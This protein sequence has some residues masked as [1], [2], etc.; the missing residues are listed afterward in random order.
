MAEP[1]TPVPALLA[2]RCAICGTEGEATELFPA[3][4]TSDAF[5][6]RHFSAR[7]LPDRV[8][9]RMVRCNRCGLIRADP[10]ADPATLAHLYERSSFDYGAEA[11]NLA[12]TYGRYLARLDRHGAYRGSLLEVGCGNGFFLEEA[13]RRGY[14]EVRGV[15]PSQDAIDAAPAHIRKLIVKDVMR[16]QLLPRASFDTACLF[17]VFDH[18]PEPGQT[19]DELREVVRPGGLVLFIHHD[20]GAFSARIL[21]ERSPIVDIEHHYLYTKQTLRRLVDA[22]GFEVVE[23]G[24]VW[25]TYS[26]SYLWRL[27]PW[28][29]RLRRVRLGLLGRARLDRVRLTVPLGNLFLVARNPA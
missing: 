18:L 15:E 20:A 19:L 13:L 27:P 17:H 5:D 22:H 6:S 8:H 12:R 23:T 16:P 9:Y 21:G 1:A 26:L 3:S 29:A 28:P 24:S 25:N 11:Q 14:A 7:R 2:T 4:F 10:A